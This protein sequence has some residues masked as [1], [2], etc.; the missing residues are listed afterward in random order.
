METECGQWVGMH[1]QA[2]GCLH[3]KGTMFL[4][5]SGI[6]VSVTP[7]PLNVQCGFVS[8]CNFNIEV[9]NGT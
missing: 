7:G 1:R 8:V 6:A 4:T 3:R 2:G 5:D 9:D